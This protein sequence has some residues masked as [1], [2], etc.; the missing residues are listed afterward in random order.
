MAY[1]F[2]SLSP[3]DFEDLVRDLIGRALSCRFEA[4][5]P[6]PDGGIDGRH[7]GSDDTII[8]QAKHYR[9]SGFTGLSRQMRHERATI[10]QLA[11]NRYIL[12]T[13]VSLTPAN[14][15][16]LAEIIGPSLNSLDDLRGFEDLNGLLREHDDVAKAHVKLWLSDTAVLERVLH[17]ASHNFTTI[18]RADITA[19]LKVY[20]QNPSFA[21]GRRTLESERILIV[22]G[23][24]G[25]GKTTLA[26]MLCYAY[27]G[28]EWELVAIRSLED[29]FARINDSR[30]QIFFFDDFLGRIAL[31][32]RALSNKDSDFA[33]FLARVARTPT[34][35]FVLTTRAYIYEQARLASESL[36]DQR[37]QVARYVLDVGVYTRRIRARI[38]YNHLVVA[39][40]PVG[41]IRALV[42]SGAIRDIVDH[43]HFNP[44]IVEWMTDAGHIERVPAG[45]YADGFLKAL[46]NPERIW[47][48]PFRNHIPRRCQHLLFALYFASEYGADIDEL[49]EVFDGIHPRLCAAFQLAHDIKDFEESLK[50][51]EGSFIVIVNR[52]VCFINPSVRDY[53]NRYLCDKGPLMIMASGAV[54]ANGAK[55]IFE[56]FQSIPQVSATDLRVLLENFADL[57]ARLKSIPFWRPNPERPGTFSLSDMGNGRR[58]GLLLGWWR[59]CALP[60]FIEA[61]T[62]IARSPL[63]GFSPWQDANALPDLLESLLSAP[64]DERDQ[65]E[66]L[67]TS[68]EEAI[69]GM[70]EQDLDPDDLDRLLNAIDAHDSV[71]GAL[72]R[73]DIA[74]AIPRLIEN[75]GENLDHVE[76]DST[77]NDYVHAVERLAQRVGYNPSAVDAAKQ[78]IQLRIEKV[79]EQA[80]SDEELSVTGEDRHAADRFDDRD[81]K[82]LFAPLVAHEGSSS[83]GNSPW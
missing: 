74:T 43:K 65:T 72:F 3:A 79:I 56:Q 55:R 10:D 22:S 71:L 35:R 25:V 46:D 7:A 82:N 36:S 23:P 6:G 13:S 33:R 29:G 68:I 64:D 14:K 67:A 26:E 47:E 28:E 18:T 40:V 21:E 16:A 51:L 17:A 20:A 39:G 73:A 69:H 49:H 32:E 41:H 48:K 30:R 34:A 50:T 27:I 78:A 2:S 75:V 5:G 61:A 77:L 80:V 31:D 45:R 70:F 1:S 83:D 59:V 9:G 66:A 76:S 11:L 24:P 62:A 4:F 38:I 42:E 63:G 60:I 12:A 52:T 19:K 8:L 57:S 15:R 44:R 81:L 58:I 37:L 54:S 53:L